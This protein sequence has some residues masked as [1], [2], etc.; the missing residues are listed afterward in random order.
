VISLDIADGAVQTIRSTVNPDT[1]IT[2]EGC[3][4]ELVLLTAR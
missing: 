3:Q 2:G 1:H 4:A